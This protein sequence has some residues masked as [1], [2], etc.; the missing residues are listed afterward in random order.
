MPAL[1]SLSPL[2]QLSPS[3]P[4]AA[5]LLRYFALS[6]KETHWKN[7]LGFE[8]K[9]RRNILWDDPCLY[10]W[11]GRWGSVSHVLVCLAA[12][13]RSTF[14]T[15]SPLLG[16]KTEQQIQPKKT[17]APLNPFC[18][19]L[20]NADFCPDSL[21][22]PKIITGETNSCPPMHGAVGA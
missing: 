14:S 12:S 21:N 15:Q 6:K 7:R 3:S 10:A 20:T 2:L 17:C 18:L 11:D 8:V 13:T 4:C 9:E 5:H 16:K 19:L 1:P 22:P